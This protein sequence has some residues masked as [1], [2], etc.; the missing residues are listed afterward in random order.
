MVTSTYLWTGAS[1]IDLLGNKWEMGNNTFLWVS[2][3]DAKCRDEYD[4]CMD[5]KIVVV[6]V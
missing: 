3:T 2:K 6:V 1:V 4:H 5:G